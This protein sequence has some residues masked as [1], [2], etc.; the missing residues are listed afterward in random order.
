MHVK[1]MYQTGMTDTKAAVVCIASCG[2]HHLQGL[3][4]LLML[5][6]TDWRQYVTCVCTPAL[7]TYARRSLLCAPAALQ[8]QSLPG[9]VGFPQHTAQVQQQA[10]SADAN[11]RAEACTGA[12][13]HCMRQ[14]GL[15]QY[16][17]CTACSCRPSEL[18]DAGAK[19]F[20][21]ATPAVCYGCMLWMHG[22]RHQWDTCPVGP[23]GTVPVIQYVA[24]KQGIT[25][26]LQNILHLMTCTL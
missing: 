4:L 12:D 21:P 14:Q 22:R 1:C 25:C 15:P 7:I 8:A 16:S 11:R 18:A 5:L 17:A 26:E 24:V 6:T 13:K 3:L 2:A 23:V 19:G 9:C 10:A 20:L